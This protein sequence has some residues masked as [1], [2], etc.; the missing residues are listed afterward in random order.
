MIN[1]NY[2]QAESEWDIQRYLVLDLQRS[3]FLH[4]LEEALFASGG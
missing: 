4:T 3:V 1:V 2:T